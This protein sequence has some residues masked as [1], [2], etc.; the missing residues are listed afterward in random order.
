MGGTS[1]PPT[2]GTEGP[3]A[4]ARIHGAHRAA[5]RP[6][7]R[8]GRERLARSGGIPE[9]A[10]AAAWLAV[11][12]RRPCAA[13]LQAVRRYRG[14]GSMLTYGLRQS[15]PVEPAARQGRP[16]WGRV[17]P[18]RVAAGRDG[19]EAAE[20]FGVILAACLELER[21]GRATA[22]AGAPAG[23]SP[24]AD[25]GPWHHEAAR[26]AR[27]AARGWPV[28]AIAHQL[29]RPAGEVELL[30]RLARLRG[31]LPQ[32]FGAGS[33]LEASSYPAPVH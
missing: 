4:R 23:A 13:S 26:A 28:T 14:W 20:A 11:P 22:A 10:K 32:G 15:G 5:S 21:R 30:L 27:L 2:I 12:A 18:S 6:T 24:P 16:G 3:M 31:D 25:R 1:R 8:E 33:G 19:A 29:G 17:P 7:G 9:A